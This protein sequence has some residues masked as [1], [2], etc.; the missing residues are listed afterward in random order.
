M[1]YCGGGEFVCVAGSACCVGGGGV[2]DVR[3]GEWT[4]EI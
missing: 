4:R 3:L 1:A 2:V